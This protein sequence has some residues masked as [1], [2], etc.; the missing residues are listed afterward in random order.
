[1]RASSYP[2]LASL[3]GALL[4]G[5]LAAAC[6]HGGA[7][8]SAPS[9]SEPGSGGVTGPS[10]F[11]GTLDSFCM[12]SIANGTVVPHDASLLPYDLNTP[13]FSD[14]AVKF[15]TLWFPK[16]AAVA[17]ADSGRFDL[18][19]GTVITKSFGFPADFRQANAPVTWLETRVLVNTAANGW[20]GATYRWNAAQTRATLLAGG[21]V[22]PIS[23]IDASGATQNAHYLLPSQA[24]CRECH[25]NNGTMTTLG[26][27]ASQLNRD[28]DYAGD[29]G[30]ENELAHWARIGV[31]TGAPSADQAPRLPVW[32]DDTTGDLPSRA[33]AYLDANCSYC[34]NGDGDARTTGLVLTFANTD[35]TSGGDPSTYG[36]CKSPVAAGKASA[37][38]QYDVVPGHP[39]LSIL[40]YRMQA[41]APSVAMPQLGRSVEHTEAV[42]LVTQ[43]IAGLSGSCP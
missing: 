34:H 7:S 37:G 26:P 39:E 36:V 6:G 27:S 16:G 10:S 22:V 13:L 41:T 1:M 32:N 8:S 4:V 3:S 25:A 23:F 15:R 40:P 21:D 9:C 19:V 17:Y 12:V 5:A 33:R 14:Y 29:A 20:T 42:Q 11:P 28:Y 38:Q 18:P 30:A 31:L 43:W 2:S 24:Q 35:P